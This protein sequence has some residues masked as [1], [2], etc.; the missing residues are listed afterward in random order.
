VN[1]R[2]KIEEAQNLKRHILGR[3]RAKY[4]SERVGV[5]ATDLL[6]PRLAVFRR[7]ESQ[8]L[9]ERDLLFFA[10]G[11]GEG[12]VIESL[13][14][15]KREVIV[16]DGDII[17]TIDCFIHENGSLIPVEIKTTRAQ[18]NESLIKPHYLL[19]LGLYCLAL[20]VNY[21]Y[22][23]ILK[24]NDNKQPL[25]AY[26]ITF[27]EE[28][29]GRLFDWREE[30][31][32][33]LLKALEYRRPE[34]APCCWSDPNLNWK[35][36][37]CQYQDKCRE[38]EEGEEEKKAAEYEAIR[39]KLDYPIPISDPAWTR[40]LKPKLL[41]PHK[42]KYGINYAIVEDQGRILELVLLA[43]YKCDR[44]HIE[45]IKRAA[46]RASQYARER[47]VKRNGQVESRK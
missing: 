46:M 22:L 43:P 26:K 14:S 29:L 10:L 34:I 7:L 25:H 18:N 13:I 39:I 44:R 35:C 8:E 36:K 33:L 24:L 47:E 17:H 37:Y 9:T 45:E 3:L 16:I 32:E 23:V 38:I 20:N 40:F 42:K 21:G 5:H 12:E 11:Q 28:D 4:E 2:P 27:S 30:R 41:E 1:L 31:K 15:D 19:Q 6:W